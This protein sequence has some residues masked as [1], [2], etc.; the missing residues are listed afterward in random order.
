MAVSLDPET[1]LSGDH[2]PRPLHKCCTHPSEPPFVTDSPSAPTQVA[3]QDSK[4]RLYEN[5]RL[6]CIPR[7]VL[8]HAVRGERLMFPFC[9]VRLWQGLHPRLV[10][11]GYPWPFKRTLECS[12]PHPLPPFYRKSTFLPCCV[13]G[14]SASRWPLHPQPGGQGPSCSA[15]LQEYLPDESLLPLRCFGTK[16]PPLLSQALLSHLGPEYITRAQYASA[17]LA[18]TLKQRQPFDPPQQAGSAQLWLGKENWK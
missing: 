1:S 3:P 7:C 5:Q 6:K 17:G 15:V 4:L 2:L 13:G 11:S 16:D 18:E 8:L 12:A 10:S 9:R 14:L